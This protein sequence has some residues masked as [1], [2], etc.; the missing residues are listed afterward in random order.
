[1]TARTA[2]LI[3]GIVALAGLSYAPK[4]TALGVGHSGIGMGKLGAASSQ[5]SNGVAPVGC[6]GVIDL[7]TGCILPT[8]LGLV[9]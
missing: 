3:L 2:F 4:V 9:P 5:G 8:A 1:M 6:S 7:S